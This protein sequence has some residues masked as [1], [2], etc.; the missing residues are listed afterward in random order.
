MIS[1][2][3]TNAED[4][5]LIFR[6]RTS[7]EVAGFMYSDHAITEDEH[8]AWFAR[9]PDDDTKRYWMIADD[10]KEIG[11]AYLYGIDAP[12]RRCHWG[13]YIV[14]AGARKRGAGYYVECLVVSEV[15]DRMNMNKLCCEV[16]E[17]NEAVWRM[18]EKFGFKREG[19]Y[20]RHVLKNG[21]FHNVVALAMLKSDWLEGRAAHV[22]RMARRGYALP[23]PVV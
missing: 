14:D 19:L 8:A 3:D 22:S 10:D 9:L 23:E 18:H 6:W 2:R 13:F 12:H 16:F 17:T 21:E 1:L 7:L 4:R 5:D 15:L 11:L 20:C